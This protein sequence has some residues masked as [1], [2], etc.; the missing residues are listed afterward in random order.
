MSGVGELHLLR[1]ACATWI[2]VNVDVNIG[3]K[4]YDGLRVEEV[5]SRTNASTRMLQICRHD[6]LSGF[7]V[8]LISLDSTG[9][10][11]GQL[12]WTVVA[13]TIGVQRS[14]KQACFS[15]DEVTVDSVFSPS[16]LPGTEA[17]S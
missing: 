8:I 7:L 2:E 11:P 12:Y 9:K 10:T 5:S 3:G 1:V 6:M 13:L 15:M 17:S 16:F 4:G 14:R